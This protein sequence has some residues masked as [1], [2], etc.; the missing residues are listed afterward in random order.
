MKSLNKL[1]E[2]IDRLDD[3]LVALL[4]ARAAV[5]CQVGE[6]KHL[7]GLPV[8]VPERE[9]SLLQRLAGLSTGPLPESGLRA[10]YREIISASRALENPPPVLCLADSDGTS[11]WVARDRLGSSLTY[12]VCPDLPAGVAQLRA[13]SASCLVL[14]RVALEAAQAADP[15]SCE[16]CALLMEWPEVL[17]P[18][19][20]VSYLALG[21]ARP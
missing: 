16:G 6:T 9:S 12:A 4:N 17:T 18:K 8:Y 5:A 7:E 1:R 14:S 11:W 20:P 19:G 3:Q 2:E 10:I 21:P 13:G 15:R